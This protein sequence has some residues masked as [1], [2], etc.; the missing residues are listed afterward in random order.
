MA[1]KTVSVDLEAYECLRRAKS[2]ARES[3]SQ[4]IK[5]AVW[6]PKGGT[7]ASLL[8]LAHSIDAEGTR[9]AD[10]VLDR[11]DTNQ[12]SDLPSPDRWETQGSNGA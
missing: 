3:F 7:A 5:R 8:V 9:L 1:T 12:D 4:V 10:D 11:L 2:S 6:P